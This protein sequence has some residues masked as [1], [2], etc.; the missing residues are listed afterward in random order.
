MRLGGWWRLWV[1]V[2]GLWVVAGLAFVIPERPT[3]G[4][5]SVEVG[6]ACGIST[7][8]TETYARDALRM[9]ELLGQ[10]ELADAQGDTAAARKLAAKII[11]MREI[12]S[13]NLGQD[14]QYTE[15]EAVDPAGRRHTAIAP[16]GSTDAEVTGQVDADTRNANNWAS[17]SPFCVDV[18]HKHATGSYYRERWQ[19]WLLTSL[20]VVVLMPLALLVSGFLIGWVW[21]GFRPRQI[22][23][24]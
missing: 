14:T 19:S 16:S 9:R 1:A 18:L 12:W 20:A 13:R 8:M 15:F 6:S 10:L 3:R 21:R 24:P 23:A 11:Q 17:L 7:P 2:S 5:V 4:S 22:A